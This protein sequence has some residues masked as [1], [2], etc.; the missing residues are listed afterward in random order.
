M[1][2]ASCSRRIRGPRRPRAARRARRTSTSAAA[3]R[4]RAAQALLLGAKVKALIDGR[5]HASYADVRAMAALS[6]RHRLLVN[7]E[8]EADKVDTDQLVK[9]ILDLTPTEGAKA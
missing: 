7:F 1:S 2:R 5:F 4:P 3:P 6:L 9:A 8:A